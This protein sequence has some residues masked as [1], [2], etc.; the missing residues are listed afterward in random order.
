LDV[1]VKNVAGSIHHVPNNLFANFEDFKL[2]FSTSFGRTPA[3]NHIYQ[4]N[5]KGCFSDII[6]SITA[7]QEINTSARGVTAADFDGGGDIDLAGAKWMLPSANY[8]NDRK[9]HRD[10]NIRAE[11]SHDVFRNLC[12]IEFHGFS[13]WKQFFVFF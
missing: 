8:L 11:D 5:T 12:T 1:Y 13:R 4:N 9:G 7:P 3:H 6:N 2:S 10:N